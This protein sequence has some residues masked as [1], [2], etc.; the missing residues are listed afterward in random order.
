MFASRT[1]LF[2]TVEYELL[3]LSGIEPSVEIQGMATYL[4][5]CCGHFSMPESPSVLARAV[6]NSTRTLGC[7]FERFIRMAFRKAR[8]CERAQL[9][10]RATTPHPFYWP[11]LPFSQADLKNRSDPA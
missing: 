2:D 1:S 4:R 11:Q 9:A 5:V 7:V 8:R 10:V 3:S 6:E